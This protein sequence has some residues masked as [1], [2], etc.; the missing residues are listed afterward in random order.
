[1]KN[2]FTF[3]FILFCLMGYSQDLPF[4]NDENL[5][6]ENQSLDILS[7]YE[8]GIKKIT[9]FHKNGQ[10]SQQGYLKKNKL[11]G[12]WISYSKTGERICIANY[13]Y[14]KKDGVWLFWEN[15][16]LKEIVYE[17]NKVINKVIWDKSG[18]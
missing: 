9:K 3:G 15:E 16:T 4:L 7:N 17:N 13:D 10:M 8:N 1:M 5:P 2:F 12:K 14:G 11:H 6:S 18:S